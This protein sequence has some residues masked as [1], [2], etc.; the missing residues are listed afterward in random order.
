MAE[1]RRRPGSIR[2]AIAL[3]RAGE[4]IHYADRRDF[5]DC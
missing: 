3:R 1:L 4:G 2:Y 5:P